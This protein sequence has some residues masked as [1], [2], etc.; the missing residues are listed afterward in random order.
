[1]LAR[2]YVRRT[3]K[4]AGIKSR[5]AEGAAFRGLRRGSRRC[6]QCFSQ[7]YQ[8]VTKFL[9]VEIILSDLVTQFFK[10]RAVGGVSLGSG[11]ERGDERGH[12][13]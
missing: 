7:C 6:G 2:R 10:G 5:P 9:N 4:D 13:V 8:L 12:F 3:E 1:M 11:L